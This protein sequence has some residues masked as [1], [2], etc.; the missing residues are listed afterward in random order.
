MTDLPICALHGFT[1]G[2][3]SFRMLELDTLWAPHLAGHGA[4]P[5]LSVRT[6]EEEI[7]RLARLIRGRFQVPIALLG[8]SM[9]ARVALGLCLR[10]PELFQ[11]V[12]LISVNPGLATQQERKDRQVWESTWIELLERDGLAQFCQ[13][14]RQL[15][16]FATQ[17]ELPPEVLLQQER[18]RCS[19]MAH[20]LSHAMRVLG[21]AAMPDFRPDLQQLQVPCRW[22]VGGKDDK[23]M[24]LA[25]ENA[26][27]S[28]M[29][30]VEIIDSAGHNSLI[31]SPTIVR[32]FLIDTERRFA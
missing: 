27:L 11:E 1:G 18:E 14:W 31:E 13:K 25:K 32:R 15:E 7:S 9:G 3:A 5:D 4:Q 10:H 28:K 12:T 8:Y 24:K 29:I 17:A 2:P 23:F 20:G 26:P 19:H 6:F 16:I 21:L 30:S 22:L